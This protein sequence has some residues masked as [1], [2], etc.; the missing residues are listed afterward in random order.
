MAACATPKTV[1]LPQPGPG[2][3]KQ[4][5]EKSVKTEPDDFR[6][7]YR[8]SLVY[9]KQGKVKKA[10]LLLEELVSS[11]G[12]QS[13][14]YNTLGAAYKKEG[15]LNEAMEAYKQAIK[16]QD[17]YVEA[18]YNLGIAYRENGQFE[19]AEREYKQAISLN[20][21]FAPAY[22]NLGILYDLY[23]NRPADALKH[24]KIY[25]VLDGST[26]NLDIWIKHL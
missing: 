25:K 5:V 16:F 4:E 11:N 7:T 18:H 17:G 13:A 19:D 14:I 1:P 23:M 3:V 12:N 22:Y 24:Y 10:R 15:M 20:P 6:K 26:D 21:N 2:A 8:K 9:L